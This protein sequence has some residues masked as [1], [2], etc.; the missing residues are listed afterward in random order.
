M[1]SNR[2]TQFTRGTANIDIRNEG[3]VTLSLGG[4]G[5]GAQGNWRYKY[6]KGL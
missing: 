2:I 3:Y 4:F 6:R 1:H 5:V